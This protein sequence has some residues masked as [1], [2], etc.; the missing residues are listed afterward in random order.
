MSLPTSQK[1][2][3]E[4]FDSLPPARRRRQRRMPLPDSPDERGAFL[5]DIGKRI[6]P[7][8]DF[9]LFSFLAGLVFGAAAF[10]DSSALLVLTALL[11]PFMSPIVGLGLGTIL[12]SVRFFYAVVGGDAAGQP[13]G[14]CG[15][16]AGRCDLAVL[17]AD[18]CAASLAARS[19]LVGRF[20]AAHA[21]R[22]AD[23]L[24]DCAQAGT[25]AGSCQYRPGV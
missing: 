16:R 6:I 12:G 19:F 20:A 15:R 13:A 1:I 2:E 11:A 14:F 7:S 22:G 23:H 17:P 5:Q 25:E 4:T 18:A 8:F 21:W 3:P 10:F 24:L 9:F